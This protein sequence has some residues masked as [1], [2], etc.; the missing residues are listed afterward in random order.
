MAQLA[1]LSAGL[2]LV[3]QGLDELD[4]HI[5]QELT[6]CS[7]LRKQA[8]VKLNETEQLASKVEEVSC[9]SVHRSRDCPGQ[10]INSAACRKDNNCSGLTLQRP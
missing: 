1:K 8:A 5:R 9:S 3:Q 6:A 7:S 2:A 10:D 4:G